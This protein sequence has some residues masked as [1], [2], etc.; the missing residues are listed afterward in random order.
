LARIADAFALSLLVSGA[1]QQALMAELSD[2]TSALPP[3]AIIVALVTIVF[4]CVQWLRGRTGAIDWTA[5]SMLAAMLVFGLAIYLF[6]LSSITPG[7][8][9]NILYG[10]AQLINTYFLFPA[11]FAELIHWL[12]LRGETRVART[13]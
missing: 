9:G 6:G 12:L 4:G 2:T 8:G 13:K 7:V 5:A 3:L 1:I 11:A 10:L